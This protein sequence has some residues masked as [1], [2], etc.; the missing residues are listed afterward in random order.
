MVLNDAARRGERRCAPGVLPQGRRT[1]HLLT[2]QVASST[3]GHT[4]PPAS[5]ALYLATPHHGRTL[6]SL[7]FCDYL[8]HVNVCINVA[9]PFIIRRLLHKLLLTNGAGGWL[10]LHPRMPATLPTAPGGA[11]GQTLGHHCILRCRRFQTDIAGRWRC[12]RAGASRQPPS[13][14]CSIPGATGAPPRRSCRAFDTRRTP[15]TQDE[16]A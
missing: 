13:R 6:R 2:S 10:A 11:G 15:G 7:S 3:V 1:S 8:S 16:R 9:S 14:P 5:P 4:P 12:D